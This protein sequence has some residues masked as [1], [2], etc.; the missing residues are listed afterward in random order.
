MRARHTAHCL[1]RTHLFTP[2][3][4]SAYLCY[5]RRHV[6]ADEWKEFFHGRYIFHQQTARLL[7]L[8]I[9][10]LSLPAQTNHK[11]MVLP[12]VYGSGFFSSRCLLY[13]FLLR[14]QAQNTLLSMQIPSKPLTTASTR[15]KAFQ[16]TT[17]GLI[18]ICSSKV[19]QGLIFFNHLAKFSRLTRKQN[20]IF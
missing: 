6:C 4:C 8:K 13:P 19:I 14:F 18:F 2:Q 16:F 17:Y 5:V 12:R 11:S 9:R 20:F 3:P 15:K 7:V 1:S 10:A